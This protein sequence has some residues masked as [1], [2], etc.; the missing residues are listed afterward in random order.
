MRGLS[1]FAVVDERIPLLSRFFMKFVQ[2]RWCYVWHLWINLGGEITFKWLKTKLEKTINKLYI[3]YLKLIT[4][5]SKFASTHTSNAIELQMWKMIS[6][7]FSPIFEHAN[8]FLSPDDS[9][10]FCVLEKIPHIRC[11]KS[12]THHANDIHI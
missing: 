5:H 3:V 8:H 2:N 9:F 7:K 11:C 4:L 6:L 12:V 10:Q 1:K